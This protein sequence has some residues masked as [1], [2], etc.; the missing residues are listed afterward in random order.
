MLGIHQKLHLMSTQAL[1]GSLG[2]AA[3]A[4]ANIRFEVKHKEGGEPVGCNYA[5]HV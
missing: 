3:F 2:R 1:F 4:W 5:P